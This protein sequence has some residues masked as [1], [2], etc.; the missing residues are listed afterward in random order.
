MRLPGAAD[1]GN[2][3][4]VTW[5]GNGFSIRG[6][7]IFDR[8]PIFILFLHC[9]L[10]YCPYFSGAVSPKISSQ[11]SFKKILGLAYHIGPD[12]AASLAWRVAVVKGR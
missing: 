6:A 3:D 12:C 10:K 2:K 11:P 7:R 1:A 8:G 9:H 5:P 4:H